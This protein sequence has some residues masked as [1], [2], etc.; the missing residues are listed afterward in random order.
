M[1]AKFTNIPLG[2]QLKFP[3]ECA[4]TGGRSPT[5]AVEV[6]RSESQMWL[7]IPLIGLFNLKRVARMRFPACGHIF[8][9]SVVLRVTALILPVGGILWAVT[10]DGDSYYYLI[11]GIVGFVISRLLLWLLLRTVR[12]VR[13]GMGSIE[14]RFSSEEYAKEFCRLNELNFR[15]HPSKKRM[16]PITVN[17]VR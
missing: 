15:S 11:C 4:F 2:A 17:D 12:I 3:Q 13:I 7:P 5:H 16:T 10:K 6:S 8:W 14:V 1:P 9:C